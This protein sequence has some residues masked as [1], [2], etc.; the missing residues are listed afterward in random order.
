MMRVRDPL[1]ERTWVA[2][3][4]SLGTMT[5]DDTGLSKTYV[6]YRI[7]Y[8]VG[9]LDLCPTPTYCRFM[10]KSAKILQVGHFVRLP[11]DAEIISK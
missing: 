4:V 3:S 1:A 11:L 5:C 10:K 8:I 9:F 7:M 6:H 2:E